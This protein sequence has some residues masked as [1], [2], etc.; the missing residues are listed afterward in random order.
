MSEVLGVNRSRTATQRNL[1][2]LIRFSHIIS[3]AVRQILEEDALREAGG[4]RMTP[5]Q[6]HLLE[7]IAG[8]GHHIDDVAKFLR[9]TPPAATKA[10]DRLEAFG[11]VSRSGCPGDRRLTL[12]TCTEAGTMLVARYR[13]LQNETVTTA[14]AMFT[15]EEI[16]AMTSMLERYSTA[17]IAADARGAELCLRCS[18]YYDKDCP[19]QHSQR[20][21]AYTTARGGDS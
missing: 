18:G 17:L 4:D 14:L 1:T 20:G 10:V 7:F 12:L 8:S 5:R 11:L 2:P 3:S 9:V 16:E 15:S 13:A 19:L 6:L 21:C